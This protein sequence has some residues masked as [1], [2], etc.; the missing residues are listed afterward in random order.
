MNLIELKGIH[1]GYDTHQVAILDDLHLSV[2]HGE[3]H[4]ISGATGCGKSSLLH[5]IAGELSRPFEG[6]M[7]RHPAL[8]VGLVMQDPNVQVLRQSVGAEIAFALENLGTPSVKMLD[9]VQQALRRVGLYVSIDTPVDVLS[10]GQK[11]RLMLAA[12]LVFEPNLLLLDEPWTQLDN[13]GVQELYFV[14]KNLLSEGVAI[15]MVE[16]H[17]QAFGSLVSHLWQLEQGKLVAGLYLPSVPREHKLNAAAAKVTTSENSAEERVRISPHRFQFTGRET[18]FRCANT[19]SLAAGEIVALVGDNGS[20][21][22][23]LLKAL[24]GIQADIGQLP[25][26]V[27]GKRPQLGI[28]GPNL[29]LLLQR[30]NRQLFEQTVLTEMQFSLRRFKLP[31]TRAEQMLAQLSLMGLAAASPHK[32]SYGQQ[33]IIA[34]AS[35]ACLTPK[36]LLLDD[37]F[38]GLDNVHCEKVWQLLLQLRQ[39]GCAILLSSHREMSLDDVDRVWHIESGFLLDRSDSM[40]QSYAG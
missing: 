7:I 27:L 36:V 39:Q 4:C 3:C 11:Y 25:F 16:H 18:L 20:G 31:L 38:A 22:S 29:S 30:P 5:L 9:K 37:P 23:S 32:L 6:E 13:H 2:N 1:F 40:E 28:Y 26:S 12:Q 35:L 33:H 10:L 19:L 15:V 21:K 24:A 14:L 8:M 34:L 17:A